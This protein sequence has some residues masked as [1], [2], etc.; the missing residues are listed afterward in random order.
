MWQASLAWDAPERKPYAQADG[1]V[2]FELGTFRGR[3]DGP[4]C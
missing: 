2:V 3:R 1:T 4:G